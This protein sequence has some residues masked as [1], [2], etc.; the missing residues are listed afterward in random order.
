MKLCNIFLHTAIFLFWPIKSLIYLSYNQLE[1]TAFSVAFI[2]SQVQIFSL[3]CLAFHSVLLTSWT[4]GGKF[5]SVSASPTA[6][7][8]L[9]SWVS[10][11]NVSKEDSQSRK[12]SACLPM[13]IINFNMN[14]RIQLRSSC[15]PLLKS[16]RAWVDCD[17]WNHGK[18]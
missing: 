11:Q 6:P 9:Q 1:E 18:G 8:S 15:Q 10:I 14:S 7:S 17:S 16:H 5:P 3:P 2:S 13:K 12:L 4:I